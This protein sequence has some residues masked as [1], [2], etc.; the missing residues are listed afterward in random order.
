[1]FNMFSGRFQWKIRRNPPELTGKNTVS[2]KFLPVS[3]CG[4]IDLDDD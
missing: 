2:C 1:M 3:E 4:I